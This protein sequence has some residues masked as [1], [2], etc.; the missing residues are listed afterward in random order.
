MAHTNTGKPNSNEPLPWQ[1]IVIFPFKVNKVNGDSH[2][3]RKN[4]QQFISRNVENSEEFFIKAHSK[5]FQY[6]ILNSSIKLIVSLQ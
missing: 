3:L 4:L 2:I 6:F 5:F 1:F